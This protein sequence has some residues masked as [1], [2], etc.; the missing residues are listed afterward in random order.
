MK[1]DP[2]NLTAREKIRL[3]V[4][5]GYWNTYEVSGKV[6]SLKMTD[7][8]CGMRLVINK[9]GENA[10]EASVNAW[11]ATR[12]ATAM[13]SPSA[14][15]TSWNPS[16]ARL[17]SEIIADDFIESDVK[18]LL[19]PG[20]NIKR[21]PLCGRNFEYFSEDPYLAGKMA[22]AYI[23]GAES[24]GVA[25][26]LKH[27]CLN[28]YENDRLY[29]STDADERTVRE[30]YLPAFEEAVKAKPA[31]VMCAY[32]QIGG[33]WASENKK[34]L[35]D[36]L[37]GEFGFDGMV[38]SDWEATHD[39]TR[40]IKA[41]LNLTMPERDFHIENL[42]EAYESGE[43]TEEEI[44]KAVTPILRFI[45]KYETKKEVKY[46]KEQRHAAAVKIAEECVALLKNDDGILPVMNGRI[47]VLGHMEKDPTMTGGGSAKVFPRHKFEPLSGLIEK[48]LMGKCEM[49]KSSRIH[50]ATVTAD[51]RYA[52]NQ[53][54]HL[55]LNSDT[56]LLCV[57]TNATIESEAIDRTSI[58]LS[59]VVEET[60]LTIAKANKNVVVILYTGSAIDMSPWI[61]SVKGVVLAGYAGEGINEALA[62]IL[63]GKVS[64]SGKLS[65][66]YPLRLEDTPAIAT[67]SEGLSAVYSA[68]QNSFTVKYTEGIFVGYRYYDTI[69]KDVLFP[70]GHGLSYASFEYS[71]LKVERK[72]D[73]DVCDFTVSFDIE[74]RSDIPA[75]ETAQ[76]YVSDII[77]T[78]ERP[79][80]ELKGFSKISLLPHEKRS[81]S[82]ELN[83]RSFAFYSTSL[84]AWHVENGL[85]DILVGSSSRDIRLKKRI[86]ITLPREKQYTLAD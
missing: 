55:A 56:V 39:A 75:M 15:A 23:E 45:E 64:P 28:N 46:T 3:L 1:Y 59:P 7:G 60:I 26:S 35:T 5:A 10:A 81:V 24:H 70:F 72:K 79:N 2:K 8:P 76:L 57:G 42:T 82:L 19:A 13:P 83:Y 38:V 40:A 4:G 11:N 33:I 52:T 80:K 14:I 86:S 54:A 62:K 51:R 17:S 47:L 22:R 20:V 78:V 37:R 27:F 36:I 12:E 21:S 16:L 74:N 61:D 9:D 31:T 43:L 6:P 73:G 65:E 77:S 53:M 85:F 29:T 66:T 32:N 25:T 58:R 41:G 84:D 49:V 67:K 34:Y 50:S 63:T 71:N 30:I 44:D 48:E 18:L 69:N 68:L